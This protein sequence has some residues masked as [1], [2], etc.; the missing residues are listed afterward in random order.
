MAGCPIPAAL[1]VAFDA[2]TL[3][4]VR[5]SGPQ[6]PSSGS[7]ERKTWGRRGRSTGAPPL[8]KRLV[9][10]RCWRSPVS[11]LWASR[12][13]GSGLWPRLFSALLAAVVPPEGGSCSCGKRFAA[14]RR[15]WRPRLPDVGWSITSG[16][17]VGSARDC[18][19]TMTEAAR[20][21]RFF[22]GVTPVGVSS[23]GRFR[24]SRIPVSLIARLAPC[25]E[26]SPEPLFLM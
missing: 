3:K 15:R 23:A 1:A 24:R 16:G 2:E 17:A 10:T 5:G 22:G 26:A 12:S 18:A 9:L 8:S 7:C 19:S 25:E 13:R 11:A 20:T 21:C 6:A 4:G 14:T